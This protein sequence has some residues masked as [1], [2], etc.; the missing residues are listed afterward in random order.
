MKFN[1]IINEND[2][3][4][5]KNIILEEKNEYLNDD[6]DDCNIK[7]KREH[8]I[9]EDETPREELLIEETP[10]KLDILELTRKKLNYNEENIN[11]DN[12]NYKINKIIIDLSKNNNDDITIKETYNNYYDEQNNIKD[13]EFDKVNN[14]IES[15]NK[16]NNIIQ[17]NINYNNFKNEK[18]NNKK[19]NELKISSSY[20]SI[21]HQNKTLSKEEKLKILIVAIENRLKSEF[22]S[23][24]VL[25]YLSKSKVNLNNEELIALLNLGKNNSYQRILNNSLGLNLIQ[26]NY[27]NKNIPFKDWVKKFTKK[28]R[29]STEEN[30]KSNEKSINKNNNNNE[31]TYKKKTINDLIFQKV[32]NNE[33]NNNEKLRIIKSEKN[34]ISTNNFLR[35]NRKKN[36]N[37]QEEGNDFSD[38]SPEVNRI[39]GNRNQHQ[40]QNQILIRD[41]NIES[42]QFY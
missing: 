5:N 16:I 2:K 7:P 24:M 10:Q 9:N 32:I 30:N 8:T 1:Q 26:S 14:N 20:I 41:I 25:N 23:R 21:I 4:T 38:L 42:N 15:T 27:N 12:N 33:N 28:R 36:I 6:N 11:N 40:N 19:F 17:N 18:R 39:F 37:I 31:K 35:S 34:L 29:Y 22:F 13:K 3:N